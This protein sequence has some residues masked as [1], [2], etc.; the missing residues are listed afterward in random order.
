MTKYH[1]GRQ[2]TT[3]TAKDCECYCEVIKKTLRP[4]S[5]VAIIIKATGFSF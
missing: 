5:F 2:R 4:H 3:G 1:K